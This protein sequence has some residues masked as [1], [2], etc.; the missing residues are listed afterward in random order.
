MFAMTPFL[1]ALLLLVPGSFAVAGDLGAD[2]EQVLRAIRQD[3][4]VPRLGY[5]RPAPPVN[6]DCDH[7]QGRY[8]EIDISVETHPNSNRAASILL[9]IP[10]PDRTRQLLPAV[11]RVIGPPD[12]SDRNQSIYS[13]DWPAYRAASVHYARGG[14]DQGLTVVSIFYR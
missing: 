9:Q 5:L 11:A 13:W 8:G 12:A 1:L 3:Q 6:Q 10:G 2:V 4:P 14:P 7:Y